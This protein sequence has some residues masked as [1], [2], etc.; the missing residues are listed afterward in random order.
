[1]YSSGSCIEWLVWKCKIS[2]V[3]EIKG[4]PLFY[5]A[6]FLGLNMAVVN[7]RLCLLVCYGLCNVK[8]LVLTLAYQDMVVKS[9]QDIEQRKM[10]REV[11]RQLLLV[12]LLCC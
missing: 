4:H 1:M 9:G 5:K 10:G 7:I 3:S 6:G 12:M 2:V 8:S 11:R